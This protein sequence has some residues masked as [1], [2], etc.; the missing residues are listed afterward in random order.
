MICILHALNVSMLLIR[1]SF[2]RTWTSLELKMS[3]LPFR[4]YKIPHFP[5][6]FFEQELD[7]IFSA[8]LPWI[9]DDPLCHV[10]ITDTPRA[11]NYYIVL[12][13]WAYNDLLH[14]NF[15]YTVAEHHLKMSYHYISLSIGCVQNAA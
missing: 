12:D 7:S 3:S 9:D 10:Q 13:Q 11:E 2:I 15:R 14:Q 8:A 1:T 5:D 4:V 6:D